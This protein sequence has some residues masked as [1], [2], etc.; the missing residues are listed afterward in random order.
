MANLIIETD[1]GHDPDDFL[2]IC[3]AITAGHKIVALSLVPG[4][5]EQVALASFLRWRTGQDFTIGV[6]KSDGKPEHLGVH[7]TLM[8]QEQAA[9]TRAYHDGSSADVLRN[10]LRLFPDAEVLVIGPPVGLGKVIRDF[11]IDKVTCQGGFLPYSQFVPGVSLD[12]FTGRQW[13]P[14]FNFNG[15]RDAIASI[16]AA[17]IGRRQF[18]GKNVCHTIELNATTS[19]GFSPP[20]D[21]ASRLYR[22]C[23]EL[24][25]QKHESKKLHDPTALVCHFHPEVGVW[26]DGRPVR[27]GNTWSTEIG[28]DRV[29]ADVNRQLLW[30]HLHNWS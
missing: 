5:P 24:Y 25:L 17:P 12:K 26:F 29:L 21:E 10:A 3:H 4:C 28:T 11:W 27:C 14:T 6:A 19:A 23:V 1:L 9:A 30:H 13:M 15:A 2:T 20:R 22:L 7:A 8:R 16:L 18:V